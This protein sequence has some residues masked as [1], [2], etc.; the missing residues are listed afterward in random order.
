MIDIKQLK[1][2][3]KF[4]LTEKYFSNQ[5]IYFIAVSVPSLCVQLR[6]KNK[7]FLIM[8]NSGIISN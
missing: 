7:G 2:P 6:D 8:E 3:E 5:N 4:N 1:N